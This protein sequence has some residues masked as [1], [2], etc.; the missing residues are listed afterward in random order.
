MTTT[1]KN[2]YLFHWL[3]PE[4]LAILSSTGIIKPYW[5]HFVLDQNRM[6]KGISFCEEPML[7]HPDEELPREPCIIIDRQTVSC[8]IHEVDS[9]QAY[10]LTKE[11]GRAKRRGDDVGEVIERAKQSRISI[12]SLPDEAF[13]EGQVSLDMIVAVGYQTA[14]GNS[15]EDIAIRFSDQHKVPTLDMTDWEVSCPG[16]RETDTIVRETI[17]EFNINASPTY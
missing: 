3:S 9:S 10:H 17:E 16:Y 13:L 12:L 14:E 15:A 8:P 1:E 11:L 5:K 6:V 2:Q 7:W 4:K